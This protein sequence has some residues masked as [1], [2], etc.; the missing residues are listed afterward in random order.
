MRA[1]DLLLGDVAALGPQPLDVRRDDRLVDLG[2]AVGAALADLDVADQQLAEVEPDGRTAPEA[3][4]DHHE[5]VVVLAGQQVV[6]AGV[7]VAEQPGEGVGLGGE[8]HRVGGGRAQPGAQVIVERGAERVLPDLVAHQDRHHL[9]REPAGRVGLQRP[10]DVAQARERRE[11]GG[12][13][14]TCRAGTP[15]AR[16]GAR[17]TSPAGPGPPRARSTTTSRRG[18]R[19]RGRAASSGRRAAGRPGRSGRPPPRSSRARRRPP[20][21][22]YSSGTNSKNGDRSQDCTCLTK[23]RNGALAHCVAAW[24]LTHQRPP[25]V[26]AGR[27]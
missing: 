8:C 1:A 15:H 23:N 17:P 7:A 11:G 24:P 16:S 6:G 14:R 2:Q 22:R 12:A 9:D 20:C 10:L 13:A 18:R 3:E 27:S 4:V 26:I 25:V 19:P 21:S 5:V